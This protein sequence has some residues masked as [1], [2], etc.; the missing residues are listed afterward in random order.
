MKLLKAKL[1][2]SKKIVVA[3]DNI[4]YIKSMPPLQELMNGEELELPIEVWEYE[5]G[6]GEK[7]G[8][9]GTTYIH[10]PY[11][12]FRG[13]QRVNA[14]IRLGYTHIEALVIKDEVWLSHFMRESDDTR[15]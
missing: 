3:L 7:T 5:K 14:A 11:M 1:V 10:K 15:C 8:V 9:N 2:N 4:K 13:S 12:T 6:T